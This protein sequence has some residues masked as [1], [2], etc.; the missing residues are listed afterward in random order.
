MISTNV[1][2]TSA[3]T[4]F[5]APSSRANR[6]ARR[7]SRRNGKRAHGKRRP[8]QARLLRARHLPLKIARRDH[9]EPASF[10][11][12]EGHSPIDD[13]PRKRF[14]SLSGR[15]DVTLMVL[16]LSLLPAASPSLCMAAINC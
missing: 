13:R 8:G 10:T 7:S 16:A 4:G 11:T 9:H 3:I 5:F 6:A 1:G 14:A 12:T 2:T 15:Y